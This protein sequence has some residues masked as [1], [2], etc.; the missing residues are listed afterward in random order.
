MSPRDILMMPLEDLVPPAQGGGSDPP[1]G[2]G[3]SPDNTVSADDLLGEVFASTTISK[4]SDPKELLLEMM[5]RER[6]MFSSK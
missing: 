5:K 1:R 2:I 3:A 6:Q 4:N